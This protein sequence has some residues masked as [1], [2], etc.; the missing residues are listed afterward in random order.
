MILILNINQIYCGDCLEVMKQ[1]DDNSVDLILCDLPYGVTQNKKDIC[2][3]LEVLWQQYNRIIKDKGVIVLTSQFP[4]TIDLILSQRK[5]FRYDLI[6]DKQLVSGFLNAKK[7]PLR[8]HEHILI[9]YKKLGTYNPQYTK[10]NPLHSEGNAC[11]DEEIKNKNYGKYYRTNDLRKGSTKKY[12]KSVLC[13]KKLHSSKTL[14]RTEKPVELAEWIIKTYSNKGDIV[15]DNCIGSGT[16]A[17]AC[18][19]TKRNF[20]GIE[21]DKVYVKIAQKRIKEAK[22]D[23]DL[24]ILL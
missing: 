23:V 4:F 24:S 10:G 21:L 16:T 6:W 17:I 3:D 1:I 5:L 12:P 15:L 2:I 20:I 18:I 7:M 14:H 13:I 19:N 9:F 8:S 11:I 22:L